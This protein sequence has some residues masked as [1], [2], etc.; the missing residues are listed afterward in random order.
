MNFK[1]NTLVKRYEDEVYTLALYLLR[2]RGEAE[3]VAQETYIKLWEK[4]ERVERKQA[5][6]WLMRVT[7]NACLDRLRRRQLE[8][9]MIVDPVLYERR[10]EPENTLIEEQNSNWIRRAIENLNEPYRSLIVLRD[11][12][13]NSYSEIALVLELSLDQV[14][15]YLHRARQQLKARLQEV[16]T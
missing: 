7:R 10:Q 9:D 1:F 4:L 16:E 8:G 6:A 14:R 11:I 2:D 3:D 5:R 15:V 12:Q 13:Q